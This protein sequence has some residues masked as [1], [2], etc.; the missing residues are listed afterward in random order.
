MLARIF[1]I[2]PPRKVVR[3]RPA[4][5]NVEEQGVPNAPEVQLQGEVTNDEF[6]KSIRF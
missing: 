1:H 3:G 4:R 6:H 5:R 2:I